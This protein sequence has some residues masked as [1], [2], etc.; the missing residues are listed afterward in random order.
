MELLKFFTCGNVDDGKSTLIGRLLYDSDSVST[1]ILQ[2]LSKQS[3]T[4]SADT[5]IDLALLTDG[6]RAERE[7]GITIDVAYKYFTTPKRKFIIVDTPGHI[8]YTRNMVTGA[9]NCELAIILIDAR[10][11]LTEQTRRHSILCSLL[12]IPHLVVCINKMDLLNYDQNVFEK[13][14]GDYQS[15]AAQLGFD[16]LSFLPL[17]A[18]AGDNVVSRSSAMPWFTGPS[19]LEKL[20]TVEIDIAP[21]AQP[22][23]QIQYVIRPQTDTLHDYRGLAGKVISGTYKVGDKVKI[24]PSGLTSTISRLESNL[25]DQ[26]K[27]EA[28][29]SAIVHLADDVDAGRGSSIVVID[30]EPTF[31]RD[32]EAVLCWMDSSPLL[33]GGKFLLQHHAQ[34]V[35]ASVKEIISVIDVQTHQELA[36]DG[37]IGLNSLCRV[38][39]KSSESLALDEYRN[40]RVTGGFILIH[41]V[42][43]ATMAAGMVEK[44]QNVMDKI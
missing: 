44:M 5:D 29:F 20:E 43:H 2:T 21:F 35:R 13:I 33:A 25:K 22:R 41:E 42:S 7:Q 14:K 3:K 34:R 4:K 19:L 15:F 38:K 11:G 37:P 23:F 24:L 30:Q 28:P 27:V 16:D 1:D 10:N 40:S 12:R 36:P 6:L 26:T 18:L 17:S 32:F 8:Q 9:S 39:I 31:T